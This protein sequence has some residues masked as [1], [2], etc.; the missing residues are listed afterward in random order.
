MSLTVKLS[1]RFFN[2]R[3]RSI[4][5]YTTN[6]V[7]DAKSVLDVEDSRYLNRRMEDSIDGMSFQRALELN[8]FKSVELIILASYCADIEP[9]RVHYK[10]KLEANKRLNPYKVIDKAN[11]ILISEYNARGGRPHYTM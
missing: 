5:I 4:I 6:G 2:N 10:F 3:E 11:E 9:I 1:G 8:K 7:G